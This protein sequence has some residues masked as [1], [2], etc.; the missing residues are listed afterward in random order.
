MLHTSTLRKEKYLLGKRIKK[1]NVAGFEPA[2]LWT[3]FLDVFQI[4]IRF[5]NKYIYKYFAKLFYYMPT[6]TYTNC[7]TSNYLLKV[8]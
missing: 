8:F 6:S 4:F 7:E 1:L 3:D 5:L 2:P